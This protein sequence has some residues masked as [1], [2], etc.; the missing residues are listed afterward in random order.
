[1]TGKKANKAVFFDRDGTLLVEVGYLNHASLVAPYEFTGEA[2]KAA[3]NS[4]FL[5]IAV[6]NQSGIARGYISESDLAGIHRRM[7]D[8]LGKAGVPL[9]AV[10]YCPHHPLGTVVEYR[11]KCDCRKPATAL[12]LQAARRFDIDLGRSYM[13]GDKET[14]ILFGKNLGV[15]PCLVRTGYGAYEER[16]VAASD[17]GSVHVFDNVLEAVDWIRSGV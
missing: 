9:D 5:L 7:Q 13:I 8:M 3:K 15:T 1:M 11:K 6:T 14:D 17:T 10:Y 12:G 4:G 16:S 2:L